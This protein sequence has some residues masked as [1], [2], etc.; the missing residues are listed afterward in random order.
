MRK[1]YQH[2]LKS[3]EEDKEMKYLYHILSLD[4]MAH[5][6]EWEED[7][8]RSTF[9]WTYEECLRTLHY[10]MELEKSFTTYINMAV[11]E[12]LKEDIEF[13]TKV[14]NRYNNIEINIEVKQ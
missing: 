9:V 7:D 12:S 13:L 1:I 5:G 10:M 6:N 14:Y 3:L 8:D 11:E 2:L 4:Y